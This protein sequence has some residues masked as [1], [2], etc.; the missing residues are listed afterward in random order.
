MSEDLNISAN[1]R[2]ITDQ[3]RWKEGGI[4]LGKKLLT[5]QVE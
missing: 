5:L 3:S 2:D 1:N 4:A